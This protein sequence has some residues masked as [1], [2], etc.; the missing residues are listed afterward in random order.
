VVSCAAAAAWAQTEGGQASTQQ[1]RSSEV[2][3]KVVEQKVQMV[4]RLLFNSPVAARVASSQNEEARRHLNQAREFLSQGRALV[5]AGQATAADSLLNK[6]IAELGRAQ[7]LVPDQTAR[8]VAERARYEQ[9]TASVTA[10][11]Q[12]YQLGVAG[13]GAIT[14]RPESTAERNVTRAMTAVEQARGL[15]ESGQVADA[16]RTLD[17]ALSLLLKDA[18]QR[19]EGK[20]VVYDKRFANAREEFAYE[21]ARHRSLEELVPLAVLEY[22]PSREALVLIDRYVQQALVMRQRAEA[23]AAAS[24]HPNALVILAEGTDALQRALRAAGLLV[25][26]TMGSP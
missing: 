10:L 19:S 12:T 13:Q 21:L 14:L 18:L 7:Q 23:Q 3:P 20:T 5:A 24:D 25:P 16:N 11:L 4:D 8:L 26:Q 17:Q 1:P 22:R 9:L 2:S 15:A 6:S